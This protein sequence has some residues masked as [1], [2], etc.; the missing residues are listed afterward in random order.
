MEI[1]FTTLLLKGR[2]FK[3]SLYYAKNV[4]SPLNESEVIIQYLGHSGDVS[5]TF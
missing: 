1:Q 3:M 5:K 2:K 4:K